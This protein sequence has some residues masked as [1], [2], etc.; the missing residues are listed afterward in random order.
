MKKFDAVQTVREIRDKIYEKTKD[1][2]DEE[3]IVHYRKIAEQAKSVQ[4]K[5]AEYHPDDK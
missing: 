1:K 4:E 3:L 5:N 2:S